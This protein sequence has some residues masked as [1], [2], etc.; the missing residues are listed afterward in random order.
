MLNMYEEIIKKYSQIT[1]LEYIDV[2]NIP[3]DLDTYFMCY[4]TISAK[5]LIDLS[6][7]MIEYSNMNTVFQIYSIFSFDTS[8]YFVDNI[9][10][11]L[12]I[13]EAKIIFPPQTIP[14]FE[15]D[16]GVGLAL[17]CLVGENKGQVRLWY[18]DG[19][20]ADEDVDR[21]LP[22]VANSITEFLGKIIKQNGGNVEYLSEI[23]EE[24]KKKGFE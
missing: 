4:D 17:V 20:A 7:D 8:M 6:D 5:P 18:Q 3:Q 1:G 11:G 14:V 21:T 12:T 22:L 13:S 19:S 10:R 9:I 2:Q 24:L 15:L 16:S 23:Y